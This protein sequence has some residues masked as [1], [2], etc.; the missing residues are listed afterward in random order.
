VCVGGGGGGSHSLSAAWSKAAQIWCLGWASCCL[1]GGLG[2][3]EGGGVRVI[4]S[5]HRRVQGGAIL[6]IGLGVLLPQ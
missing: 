1:G 4:F 2:G 3:G 6:G 5:V